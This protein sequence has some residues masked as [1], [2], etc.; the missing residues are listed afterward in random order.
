MELFSFLSVVAVSP[1][2]CFVFLPIGKFDERD[3]LFLKLSFFLSFVTI[4]RVQ[5]EELSA[6]SLCEGLQEDPA[7]LP[8]PWNCY[9]HFG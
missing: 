2:L 1:F 7:P 5:D 6:G 9:D 8:V 4:V 3:N